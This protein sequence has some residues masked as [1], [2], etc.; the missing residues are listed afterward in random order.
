MSQL[1]VTVIAEL[2]VIVAALYLYRRMTGCGRFKV[3]PKKMSVRH[4]LMIAAG[5]FA[6]S[7]CINLI[8]SALSAAERV[9]SFREANEMIFSGTLAVQIAHIVFIAPMAEEMIFRGL[10]QNIIICILPRH[11]AIAVVIT[12][13]LFGLYHGNIVQGL[14]GF[15]TGL[16]IG[17]LYEYF[18]TIKAPIFFHMCFNLPGVILSAV[19][20]FVEMF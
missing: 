13:A 4:Y 19:S 10:I 1:M 12:A 7:L 20:N 8:L 14:A 15:V 18:G 11:R 3:S 17:W 6:L 9:E 16:L 5:A 2:I